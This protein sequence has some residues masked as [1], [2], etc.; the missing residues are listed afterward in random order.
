WLQTLADAI[1]LVTKEDLRPG[2]ADR[3]L[4]LLAPY[5]SFIASFGGYM[6]LPFADN[7][8]AIRLNVAV[9]FILAVLGLEVFGVILAGY[10][11]GTKWELVVDMGEWDSVARY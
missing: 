3:M 2:G 5:V 4:F 6:A 11:S 10:A 8:V 9:F 7:W 1:K